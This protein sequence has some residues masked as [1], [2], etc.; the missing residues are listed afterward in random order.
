MKVFAFLSLALTVG[1]RAGF[2]GH[3]VAAPGAVVFGP[4]AVPTGVFHSGVVSADGP[5]V[6]APDR[7]G[8]AAP[9][10][11]R[12]HEIH[13][14][15]PRPVIRVEEFNR[16]GQVIRVHEAPQALP[17]VFRLQAPHEPPTV[18]RVVSKSSGPAQV[19]R[20]VYQAPGVQVVNVQRPGPPPARIVQVVRSPAPAPRVEFIQ[21][22]DPTANRV[23]VAHQPAPGVPVVAGGAALASGAFAPA[24]RPA[25]SSPAVEVN[26]A[27]VVAPSSV[28]TNAVATSAV[29]PSP[30]VQVVPSL[31]HTVEEPLASV[32]T[33]GSGIIEPRGF[34]VSVR[35]ATRH[36]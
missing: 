28:S 9:A 10:R 17:Q 29:V 26:T 32:L 21:E 2:L 30:Q 19:E 27:Q 22:P 3:P 23:Y 34:P 33:D 18:V 14:H 5:V 8:I 4:A 12:V 31:G 24:L 16:P 25:V 15:E 20:V 11:P 36:F 1:A 7:V 13:T 35:T 6:A